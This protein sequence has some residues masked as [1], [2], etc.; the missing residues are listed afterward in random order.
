MLSADYRRIF[1]HSGVHLIPIVNMHLFVAGGVGVRGIVV[2]LG[3]SVHVG[4]RVRTYHF[5]TYT[6]ALG[7]RTPISGGSLFKLLLH[8]SLSAFICVWS[9]KPP[10]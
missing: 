3:G 7:T 2:P 6:P 1:R 4:V 10:R 9:V 8:T 5:L